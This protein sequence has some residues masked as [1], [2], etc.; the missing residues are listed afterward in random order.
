M[1]PYRNDPFVLVGIYFINISR[2]DDFFHGPWLP[3]FLSFSKAKPIGVSML[4]ALPCE[5]PGKNLDIGWMQVGVGKNQRNVHSL[6]L[7]QHLKVGHSKRKLVLQSSIFKGE[8]VFVSG[9]VPSG[10]WFQKLFF[11]PRSLGEMI[12]FDDHIFQMGWNHQLANHVLGSLFFFICL[13]QNWMNIRISIW[14]WGYSSQLCQ[15]TRGY[16]K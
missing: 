13:E 16:S 15:Y 6:T 4:R 12:R 1:V 7:T 9:N 10:W 8:N 5:R 11:S 2:V 3:G 14:T